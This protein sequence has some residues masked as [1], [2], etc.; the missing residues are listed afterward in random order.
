MSISNCRLTRLGIH[1]RQGRP[2]LYSPDPDYEAKEQR[3]LE[4]LSEAGTDDEIVALFLDELTYYHWPLPASDWAEMDGPPPQAERDNPG[5]KKYRIVGALN[6]QTGRV[7][8]RQAYKIDRWQFIRFLSQ[9][10]QEYPDAKFIYI[11][12]D[13]WPVHLAEDVIAALEKE[14][15]LS[16]I[17]LVFLPTYSPWLNPIEKLWGWLKDDVLKMHRLAGQWDEVKQRVTTFLEQFAEGSDILIYRVGLA[18]DGKLAQA[19]H[20]T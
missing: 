1:L 7:T 18:G 9:V 12:L 16:R 2:Q 13:N 14:D 3:L 5:E 20:T 6:A 15:E 19:V 4:V 11:V 17:E 10:A 8:Y